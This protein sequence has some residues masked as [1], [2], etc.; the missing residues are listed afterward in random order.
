M[1]KVVTMR[2]LFRLLLGASFCTQW[3]RTI[4]VYQVSVPVDLN[5]LNVGKRLCIF[6]EAL[7]IPDVGLLA[8]EVGA[9]DMQGQLATVNH[10]KPNLQAASCTP[11]VFLNFRNELGNDV[12]ILGKLPKWWFVLLEEDSGRVNPGLQAMIHQGG[13]RW[14]TDH[15]RC[16]GD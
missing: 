14:K 10:L 9:L 11:G 5:P 13:S 16:G 15:V 1:S 8:L 6:Q 3:P 7:E 2:S 12:Q 4:S